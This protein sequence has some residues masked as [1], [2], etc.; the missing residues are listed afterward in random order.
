MSLRRAPRTI[1]LPA[2]LG[3]A[4]SLFGDLTLFAVLVTRLDELG[5]TFAQAGLLLSVHRLIRIPLNP[6][7]GWVH[8]HLGRRLPFL[9]GLALGVVSTAACGLA[10]GFWPFFLARLVWGMAWA[11]INVGGLAI[12]LD[13]A[14]GTGGG[15]GH[16]TGLYN[17]WMWAGYGLGPVVGSF[18]AD[19]FGFQSSMLICAGL[20]GVGLLVAGLFLPETRPTV[21]VSAEKAPRPVS[22]S[23]LSPALPLHREMFLYGLNQLVVDGVILSTTTLL[24]SQRIGD[25]FGFFGFMVSAGSVGGILLAGRSALAAL[26]S[27]LIGR[28]TDG[29]PGRLPALSGG[30]F[31]GFLSALLLIFAPSILSILL[32]VLL[33]ALCATVLLVVI[34]AM[35]GDDTPAVLRAR[36]TGQLVTAGDIGSTLGPF[37]ALSLAPLLGLP[38]VYGG[39]AALYGLGLLLSCPP[40]RK[41]YLLPMNENHLPRLLQL[42]RQCEDFL[43]L[44]LNPHASPEMVLADLA[45]SRKNGGVFYGIFLEKQ[46]AGVLDLVTSGFQSDARRAYLELLMIAPGFRGR[47][48]GRELLAMVEGKLQSAGITALEADVQVNNPLGLRFWQREG[49]L[50]IG[51]SQLQED[52]TTTIHLVKFLIQTNHPV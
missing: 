19:R 6:I 29:Q 18:L 22:P 8:D 2:G 21:S 15:R 49:F 10:H 1:L 37:A 50:P 26:L 48:L 33:S 32:G 42:Y 25:R 45:L 41:L 39:C 13:L 52:G 7:T 16:L 44:G 27:P 5:L 23:I 30:L 4:L 46:L 51:Q 9:S 43:S 35:A 34:P 11:L 17:T 31:A 20:S 36:I 24:V 40:R 12:A 14:D 47:G 38:W 3:M 28:L